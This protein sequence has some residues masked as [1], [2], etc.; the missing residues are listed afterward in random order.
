MRFLKYALSTFLVFIILSCTSNN[1]DLTV[2]R[3]CDKLKQ[4]KVLSEEELH[5]VCNSEAV[6]SYRSE[7]YFVCG[8]CL[9]YNTTMPIN[10]EGNLPYDSFSMDDL[11]AFYTEAKYHFNIVEN[12][13]TPMTLPSNCTY[14]S[15]CVI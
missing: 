5:A 7:V 15:H 1:N 4:S 10:C 12:I 6:Y 11:D 8:C 14:Q 2:F 9:C 13:V 3:D